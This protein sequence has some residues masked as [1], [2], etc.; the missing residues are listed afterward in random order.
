M[1]R[2]QQQQQ[3]GPLRHLRVYGVSEW[4]TTLSSLT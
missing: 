2:Y 3:F 1:L 4:N